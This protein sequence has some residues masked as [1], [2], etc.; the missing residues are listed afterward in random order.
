MSKKAWAIL[1]VIVIAVAAIWFYV[2]NIGRQAA[3]PKVSGVLKVGSDVT[4]PPFEYVD[5]VTNE[6]KGFDMDLIR[7]V[8]GVMGKKVEVTNVAWDGLLPGLINGNY[9]AVI[10]AMTITDER[11]KAVDFSDP[12]F[13]TGQVIV[14]RL[15]DNSIKTV[16][17]LKGKVVSVQLGTTGDFAASKVAGVKKIS[18]F[19]TTPEALQELLNGAADASVVDELVAKEFVTKNPG[20]VKMSSVFTVEYYGIAVKK[21]NQALLKE[22]NRAL[23][24][25]KA[26]GKYDEIYNKWF[27]QNAAEKK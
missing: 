1:L 4:Y 23:A 22:I 18:R 20:K 2:Q 15:G 8:G 9:D 6:Y 12:Y 10:S 5:E 16:D 24:T 3:A 21:G 26:N 11:A 13:T 19:S 17:D 7:A 27:G 14:T 25:L